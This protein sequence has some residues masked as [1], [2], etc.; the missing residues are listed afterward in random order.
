M[1]STLDLTGDRGDQMEIVNRLD[2]LHT[3]SSD[4]GDRGDYMETRLKGDI[5]NSIV[6]AALHDWHKR[7]RASFSTN[8]KQNKKIIDKYDNRTL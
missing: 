3:I 4:R 1:P 7:S 5:G 8:E 2:R 6:I